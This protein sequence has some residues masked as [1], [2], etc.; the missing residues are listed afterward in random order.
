MQRVI[1]TIRRPHYRREP[2]IDSTGKP[3]G[4]R[5][6]R[7]G[8]DTAQVSIYLDED[9]LAQAIGWRAVDNKS[10]KSK[11]QNGAITVVRDWLKVGP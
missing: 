4:Y 2:F 1:V 11:L 8:I 6:V 3:N 7:E 9:K 10:G 5:S